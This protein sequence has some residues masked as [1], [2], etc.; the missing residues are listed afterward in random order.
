MPGAAWHPHDTELRQLIITTRHAAGMGLRDWLDKRSHEPATELA[1]SDTSIQAAPG[2]KPRVRFEIQ[3]TPEQLIELTGL[4][5]LGAAAFETLAARRGL[6]DRIEF[7]T[8][9]I[10]QREPSNPV[11]PDAVQVLVEGERIG[12]LPSYA[13]LWTDLTDAGAQSVRLQL[14]TAHDGRRRWNRGWVWL[15]D[16]A[17]EWAWSSS[18]V[19]PLTSAEKRVAAARRIQR[20][21]DDALATGGLR[22]DEF[23]AGMVEGHHYLELVEPISELKRQG[24]LEQALVLCYRAI[25]GAERDLQHDRPAPWYTEQAAIVHH[26]LRQPDQEAAVLRRW[27][28]HVP[29]AERAATALG[30]RLVKLEQRPGL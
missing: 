27:L 9:A 7:L 1:I 14:F 29:E 10:L 30:Q 15:P 16:T 2:S 19:P 3:F 17:P 26:K 21:V 18:D 25:D 22:A 12:Y 28:Q 20:T 11:N 23:S 4:T 6:T 5:T 8:E 24:R 13:V